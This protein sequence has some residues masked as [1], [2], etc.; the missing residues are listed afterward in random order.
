MYRPAAYAR[1][2]TAVL[3]DFIRERSFA[4]IAAVVDGSVQFAYVPMVLDSDEGS[5]GGARF[6]LARA[7][8]L[9][10]IDGSKVLISFMG[11]DAYVSPDWYAT[12]DLVPTW[13]Y[14]AIE[15]AGTAR[16]LNGPALRRL[17]AD[18]SAEHEKR[19]LPKRPWTLDKLSQQR[20]DALLNAIVGFSVVFDTLEG[21]FKLSQDKKADDVEHVMAALEASTAPTSS[22]LAAAMRRF[23]RKAS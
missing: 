14:I 17:L 18:L 6:H 7:N 3:H 16:Q 1:D 5:H 22:A 21:K 12:E 4:V 8:P 13:N 2:E 15:A 10:Q 23:V 20:L 11:P 19:L 9:A